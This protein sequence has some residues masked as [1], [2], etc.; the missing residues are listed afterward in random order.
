M[1]ADGNNENQIT[2]TEPSSTSHKLSV[3]KLNKNTTNKP[4]IS[5]G[6]DNWN[7]VLHMIFGVSKSVVNAM[8]E[9]AFNVRDDDFS[10]K[11]HYELSQQTQ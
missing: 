11:Y 9:E 6:H 7:L 10:R 8:Y 2:F 4:F 1:G 3:H 5:F